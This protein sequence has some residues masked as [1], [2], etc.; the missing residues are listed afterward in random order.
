MCV[1]VGGTFRYIERG[2]SLLVSEGHSNRGYHSLG[3]LSS[4]L[5]NNNVFRYIERGSFTFG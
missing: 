5:V 2:H 1:C 4:F 3:F